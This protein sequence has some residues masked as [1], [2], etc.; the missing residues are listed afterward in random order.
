MLRTQCRKDR[1]LQRVSSHENSPTRRSRSQLSRPSHPPPRRSR[2]A[3]LGPKRATYT[4]PHQHRYFLPQT[5]HGYHERAPQPY[6]ASCPCF[7]FVSLL[8]RYSGVFHT[9]SRCDSCFGLTFSSS[10]RTFHPSLA[11]LCAWRPQESLDARSNA[12][13]PLRCGG[14]PVGSCHGPGNGNSVRTRQRRH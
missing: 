14:V 1:A 7:I 13:T 8:S 12:P 4:H 10:T 6:D 3:S 2:R 11:S 5:P 9:A